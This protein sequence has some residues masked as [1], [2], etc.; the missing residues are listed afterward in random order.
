VGCYKKREE[1]YV[2]SDVVQYLTEGN[3]VMIKEELQSPL[4]V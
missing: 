2:E 3:Q 1:K 4:R